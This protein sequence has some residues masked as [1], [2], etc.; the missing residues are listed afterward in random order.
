VTVR[1][2]AA[3]LLQ[4]GSAERADSDRAPEA[5]QLRSTV[6]TFLTADLLADGDVVLVRLV[7]CGRFGGSSWWPLLLIRAAALSGRLRITA[8]RDRPQEPPMLAAASVNFQSGWNTV[9]NSVTAAVGTQLTTLMTA[10][11]VVLV[12][13]AIIRWLWDRR[14]SGFQGNHSSLLWTFG[15]GAVLAAP[16]A[17]MPLLL[18]LA[19]LI[20][21]AVV[22][23]FGNL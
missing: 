1:R 3:R 5:R 6:G 20:T 18:G 4:A 10:F 16:E 13:F 15:I 9:W 2:A 17:I 12:A 21:N 23:L 7:I 19:D 22:G 14:R 8:Q 11:G